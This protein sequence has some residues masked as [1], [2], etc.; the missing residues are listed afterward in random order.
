MY[1]H[2][3]HS[4]DSD[5]QKLQGL[6]HV[7]SCPRLRLAQPSMVC[8]ASFFRFSG[9]PGNGNTCRGYSELLAR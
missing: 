2:T 5:S 6:L 4:R 7:H 3:T 8:S 9:L 1:K